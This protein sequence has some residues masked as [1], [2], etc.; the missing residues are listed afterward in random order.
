MTKYLWKVSYTADGAKGLLAEGGSARRAAIAEVIESVG[1]TL[2]ACYYALGDHDLY[3]IGDVPD[4]VAAA[5][6]SIRTA[7]AGMAHSVS[8]PLLTPEEIDA[9]AQANVSYRPPH[10]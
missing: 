7:A 6:M 9:A 10:D 1:G 2:E 3:V 5:A 4:H 8:I